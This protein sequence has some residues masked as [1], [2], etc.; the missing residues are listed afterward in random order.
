M[1]ASVIFSLLISTSLLSSTDYSCKD[2]NL[3]HPVRNEY[4]LQIVLK[5]Y[6]YYSGKIDGDIGPISKNALILFQSTNNLDADG[7][8]G[9]KTCEK[10]LN[11]KVLIKNNDESN[12]KISNKSK[13]RPDIKTR[14]SF[15]NGLYPTSTGA[16]K[17]RNEKFNFELAISLAIGWASCLSCAIKPPLSA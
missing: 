7:I 17:L 2:E 3:I 13:K 8:L 12:Y 15:I 9:P 14:Q 5:S 10:L 1:L 16:T 11:K 4:M 6:K